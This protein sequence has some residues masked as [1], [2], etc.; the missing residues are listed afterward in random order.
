MLDEHRSPVRTFLLTHV[1][2]ALISV[3]V[4][5]ILVVDVWVSFVALLV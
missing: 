5:P 1:E 3:E 2:D 4:E